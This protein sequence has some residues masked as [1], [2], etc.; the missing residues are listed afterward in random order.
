MFNQY[1]EF[2][3]V[4]HVLGAYIWI[5]LVLL[6]FI[7]E[8]VMCIYMGICVGDDCYHTSVPSCNIVNY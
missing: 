8:L 7:L 5:L 3:C 2:M 1:N 6:V 4:N